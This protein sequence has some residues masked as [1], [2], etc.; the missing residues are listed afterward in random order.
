MKIRNRLMLL[1]LGACTALSACSYITGYPETSTVEF[2]DNGSIRETSVEEFA[3]DYYDMAELK[4]TVLSAVNSYNEAHEGAVSVDLYDVR[5][6]RVRLV[7]TYKDTASYT[8]FNT[9]P[10]YAGPAGDYEEGIPEETSF[11]KVREDLTLKSLTKLP[12][13]NGM[14]LYVI[15]DPVDVAVSGR[16]EYVSGDVELTG[17]SSCRTGESISETNPAYIA[18]RSSLEATD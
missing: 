9:Q 2:L 12:D 7:M 11:S 14:T 6:R 15:T 3:E 18:A 1:I 17:P 8:E 5:A 10:L 13:L 16:I 4:D